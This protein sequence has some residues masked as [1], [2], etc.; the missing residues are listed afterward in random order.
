MWVKYSNPGMFKESIW[1]E[2]GSFESI[3]KKLSRWLRGQCNL[4]ES[5]SSLIFIHF[6]MSSKL[7]IVYTEFASSTCGSNPSI[8]W[9]WIWRQVQVIVRLGFGFVHQ[10][11]QN[12]WTWPQIQVHYG[13][14]IKSNSQVRQ[15]LDLLPNP[16][17][18]TALYL[19]VCQ[20][21]LRTI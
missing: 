13:L 18:W 4:S 17:T 20:G 21:C 19:W 9:T 16:S 8:C 12:I 2:F 11:H 3:P 6:I 1:R 5:P 10:V 7:Y 14:D 15:N